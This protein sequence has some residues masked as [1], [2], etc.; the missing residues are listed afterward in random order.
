MNAAA[1]T[2]Q[3]LSHQVAQLEQAELLILVVPTWWFGFPSILKGWFDRLWRP[4]VAFDHAANLGRITPRLTGLRHV[5][6]VT[7]LGA[8]G[9]VDWLVLRRPV[10]RITRWSIPKPCAPQAQL[11]FPSL[12]RA[13]TTDVKTARTF[14]TKIRRNDK[15][16][17]RV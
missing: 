4:G 1:I 9:R 12:Y 10:R 11:Q 5:I 16:I 3:P 17:G 14:A 6:A 8:P 13:E 15:L 7:T 2:A